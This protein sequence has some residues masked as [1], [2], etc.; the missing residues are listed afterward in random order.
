MLQRWLCHHRRVL[1][2]APTPH[3]QL[4]LIKVVEQT[5]CCRKVRGNKRLH[6]IKG[7]LHY[8]RAFVKEATGAEYLRIGW[9]VG[10]RES[11]PI[12]IANFATPDSVRKSY[13]SG[14]PA[15][16]YAPALR[17]GK[18]ACEYQYRNIPGNSVSDLLNSAKFQADQPDKIVALADILPSDWRRPVGFEMSM[19]GDQL[20]AV[21]E[22]YLHAPT[23][24]AYTFST[25]SDDASEVWAAEHPN[26]QS[27]LVKVV[28]LTGCCRKV[29]GARRMMWTK[30]NSYYIRAYVKEGRGREYLRIGM[31]LTNDQTDKAV[32][33]I[34]I[35]MFQMP[36][37]VKS[38]AAAPASTPVQ[39]NESANLVERNV[40]G[41]GAWGGSCTCPDG[42]VYFVGDN[43]DYCSSLACVGGRSGHCRLNNPGGAYTRVTCAQVARQTSYPQSRCRSRSVKLSWSGG[44]YTAM[45][46]GIGGYISNLS[47]ATLIMAQPEEGCSALLNTDVRGKLLLIKRGSCTLF[48][49]AKN[50]QDIGASA[51]IIYNNVGEQVAMDDRRPGN[52]DDSLTIPVLL[53]QRDDGAR[54]RTQ[55]ERRSSPLQV[56]L[57]CTED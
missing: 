52:Y 24:G 12:P 9:R 43:N 54:L 55:A 50:A 53:L 16:E 30:G 44:V 5:G 27:G 23:T 11:D 45:R 56:R 7:D 32:D 26:T 41:V 19:K 34:P 4:G 2:A 20:G 10:S 47:S 18:S 29:Y 36:K 28:E 46:A 37:A 15:R 51:A 8:V 35:N 3:T 31:R 17:C 25:R 57:N 14:R 38:A 21:L 6:L 1:A 13:S 48:R 22:G 42:N 33:P 39:A 40:E 49:K